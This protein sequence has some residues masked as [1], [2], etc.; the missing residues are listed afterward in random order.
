[1]RYMLLLSL[2][3]LALDTHAIDGNAADTRSKERFLSDEITNSIGMKLVLLPQGTFAMGSPANQRDADL[4]ERQHEVTIGRDYYIGAYECTQA[5]YERVMG[6]NP[7]QFQTKRLG[8]DSSEYPVEQ[9]SWEEATQFCKRLSDLP[10]E[11]AAGRVYRLP[12]EAEWEYACRAGS[13]TD[14]CFG[15]GAKQLTDYAWYQANSDNRT[16]PVGKKKPNAWGLYDMHGNAWEWCADWY[17]NYPARPT[18]DNSGPKIGSDRVYRGGSWNYAPAYSRSA[19]RTATS[20]SFKGFDFLSISFRVAMSTSQVEEKTTTREIELTC[21]DDEVI[22]SATFQSNTQHI[23]S[24]RK[25]IFAAFVKSRNEDYTS[26]NWR[27]VRSTDNGRSFAVIAEGVAATNPPVLETDESDNLYLCRV[28]WKSNNSF[29]DVFSSK[30][31]F[32]TVRTLELP[33]VS[34]GKFAMG[35]DRTRRNLCYMT[36]DGVLHRVSVDGQ[37]KAPIKLLADGEHAVLQY[38]SF[39]FD[40]RNDLYLCWTTVAHGKYLYRDIHVARSI[41]GGDNWETLSGKPLIVPFASDDGGPADLI[42][43]ESEFDVTTWLANAL[44]RFGKLHAIYETQSVPRRYNYVRMDTVRGEIDLRIAPDFVGSSLRLQ[45]LD[46]GLASQA[47]NPDASIF[48]VVRDANRAR[49]AC[50]RSDDQGASWRDWAVSPDFVSPYAVGTC[51]EI[52]A[53]DEVLG[54]FTDAIEPNNDN[55]GKS[56]LYFFRIPTK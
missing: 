33:G 50:V 1:M 54:L 30:D 27:L 32:K 16:H 8:E 48:C 29:I 28:D 31:D 26:Q 9:L 53:K 34:G 11:K 15:D 6:S 10:E 51:R 49:L 19:N 23:V 36:L 13:T 44:P 45:G 12:S 38:P 24:N 2:A 46:G 17:G 43:L 40:E 21:I 5:Q 7:S 55:F 14:Y 39:H 20:P 4:D 56:K 22:H 25:G 47:G 3:F 52:S 18:V 35:L 41:D 37:M 42:S